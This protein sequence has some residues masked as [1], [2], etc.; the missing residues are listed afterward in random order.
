MQV[1]SVPA[2]RTLPVGVVYDMPSDRNVMRCVAD[3]AGLGVTTT[4]PDTVPTRSKV[5][6]TLKTPL[7]AFAAVPPPSSTNAIQPVQLPA[8]ASQVGAAVSALLLLHT[9]AWPPRRNDSIR[10]VCVVASNS[11]A[12]EV[13]RLP[14]S[15]DSKEGWANDSK[16]AK[17]VMV[18][19]NSIIENPD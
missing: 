2:N 13:R 6:P 19:I 14:L 10:A 11:F 15:N 9:T 5:S 17:T 12:M 7:V 8:V 3:M 4:V 16:T 18:I 1:A